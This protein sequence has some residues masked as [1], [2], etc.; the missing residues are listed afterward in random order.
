MV[1]AKRPETGQAV[2]H[3]LR[4]DQIAAAREAQALSQHLITTNRGEEILEMVRLSASKDPDA[5]LLSNLDIARIVAPDQAENYP[6]NSA[7]AIGL[8]VRQLVSSDE[9]NALTSARTARIALR[10][11]DANPKGMADRRLKGGNTTIGKIR[12]G[13]LKLNT[14]GIVEGQGRIPWTDLE[15]TLLEML[16]DFDKFKHH[17]PKKPQINGK[18]NWKMIADFLNSV[19]HQ[20]QII[21]TPNA[22]IHQGIIIRAAREASKPQTGS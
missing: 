15:I 5:P 12:S 7:R 4:P 16:M 10:T 17:N 22:A 6:R 14:T 8:V 19:I 3:G 2:S 1:E 9:A 21:R 20:G 13:D 18:P 11:I